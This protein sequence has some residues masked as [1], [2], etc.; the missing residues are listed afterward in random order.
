M[1]SGP[2]I[3]LT[4]TPGVGKSTLGQQLAE[5]TGLEWI[6]VGDLAKDNNFFD[7][8]DD[9]RDCPILDD[10]KVLDELEDMIEEGG[11]IIDYHGCEFFPERFFDI[12]FVLRTNNTILYDRLAARGYQGKKLEDNVTCEIMNVL[13]DEAQDSYA[14]QL[15]HELPSN[16]IEDMENNLERIMLWLAAWKRDNGC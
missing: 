11:K 2:N 15:V 10:D 7:G 4:G 5:R 3:L 9:E 13:R 14:E 16:T 12:V 6:S 8:Y 1:K